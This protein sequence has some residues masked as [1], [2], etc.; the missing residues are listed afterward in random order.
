MT[1]DLCSGKP[2][3]VDVCSVGALSYSS[4]GTVSAER[5][6]LFAQKMIQTFRPG[7]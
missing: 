7:G 4:D 5:K 1:C 6:K 3:C 2:L